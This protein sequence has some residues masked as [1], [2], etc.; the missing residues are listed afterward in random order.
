M[1]GVFPLQT[2][3]YANSALT[4]QAQRQL[5]TYW[6]LRINKAL[7]L[8]ETEVRRMVRVESGLERFAQDMVARLQPYMEALR[9][10]PPEIADPL[11]LPKAPFIWVEQGVAQ[12]RTREIKSR[13]RLLAKELHPDA[14]VEHSS[15]ITMAQVNHAYTR[16][17][18]ALL[19]RLE[20]QS[21]APDDAQPIANFE[22]YV[23]QVEQ[24]TQTYRQAYTRLLNS[25]LYSLY[26]RAASAQED[27]WDFIE[28]L[29]RRIKRTIESGTL[30]A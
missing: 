22:D 17:D 30:A 28:S 10:L 12:A 26:A 21:L 18:L 13:Y 3:H 4:E 19:V 11:G 16:E 29:T 2:A 6:R 5:M 27:G 20:A 14:A 9:N 25:P 23:R 1:D 24:A 15:G 7:E 8:L